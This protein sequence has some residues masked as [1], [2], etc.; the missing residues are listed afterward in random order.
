MFHVPTNGQAPRNPQRVRTSTLCIDCGYD[1]RGLPPLGRCP[2]CATDIAISIDADL[3]GLASPAWLHR[4]RVGACFRLGM[5]AAAV[6][7]IALDKAWGTRVS[8]HRLFELARIIALAMAAAGAWLLTT[9]PPAEARREGIATFR[10][11]ARASGMLV[12]GA[13][14]LQHSALLAGFAQPTSALLTAV[15]FVGLGALF[16]ELAYYIRLP[17]RM[18]PAGNWALGS[19]LLGALAGYGLTNLAALTQSLGA[20]SPVG[21]SDGEVEPLKI[22]LNSIFLVFARLGPLFL[23]LFVVLYTAFFIRLLVLVERATAAANAA[24]EGLPQGPQKIGRV[25]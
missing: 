13:G 3:R 25:M 8:P 2:E 14:F 22:S 1:L 21:D 16:V 11:F 20:F 23:A 4:L 7:S 15:G 10:V 5:V 24:R 18:A 6:L 12:F 19:V 17:S 9:G